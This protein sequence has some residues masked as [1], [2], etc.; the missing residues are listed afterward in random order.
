MNPQDVRVVFMGSPEFAVPSLNALRGAGY[1]VV[2]AVSQPDRPAG[3]GG[4]TKPPAVKL[5][6]LGHG[7]PVLQPA[8]FQ[9][10]GVRAHLASLTA[11]L[12]VVAAYGKILPRAVLALPSRGCVNVH[13]SLLPRWRG[14]SP[15]NAAVLAGDSETGVTI[16]EMS[17]KMDAGPIIAV[18]RYPLRGDV[19]AGEAE[20]DLAAL[21]A[22]TLVASL[23]PWYAG[24]LAAEP[25]DEALVTYCPLLAKADGHLS[26]SMTAVEAERAVRAYNPWPGA[27][28]QYRGARLAVWRA[29]VV[30]DSPAHRPGSLVLLGR[31]PA[32]ALARGL[33]VLEE[34]QRGGS[35]RMPG[36]AF[37]NGERSNLAPEVVLA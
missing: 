20:R 26:A 14:P 34:V 17:A 19:F 30:P 13:A 7:L 25:Q 35:R 5:A 21:G 1:Q 18:A 37:V 32:V 3:R 8:S 2:A 29:R 9:D 10:E 12:F 31:E 23:P 27:F 4:A 28:V 24:D 15:I 33:L 16:M 6:A 22:R 36:A 11:D